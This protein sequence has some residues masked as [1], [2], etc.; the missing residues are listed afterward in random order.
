[1][2]VHA[3][4]TMMMKVTD[5]SESRKI[6]TPIDGARACPFERGGLRL[7]IRSRR[8]AA[9]LTWSG[10]SWKPVGWT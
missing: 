3:A 7:A 1:V 6:H 4:N 10:I 9:R 2:A 5:V 8:S